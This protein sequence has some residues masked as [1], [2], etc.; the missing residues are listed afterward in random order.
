MLTGDQMG[1]AKFV[2]ASTA[3]GMFVAQEMMK[4]KRLVCTPKLGSKSSICGFGRNHK[5]VGIP[6]NVELHSLVPGK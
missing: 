6:L 4:L 3:M 5:A 2:Q 1:L